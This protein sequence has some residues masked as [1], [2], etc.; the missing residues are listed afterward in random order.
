M[1]N[2][3]TAVSGL[4]LYV[5]LVVFLDHS[6]SNATSGADKIFSLEIWGLSA[7]TI[8]YAM[9]WFRRLAN[10]IHFSE[11]QFYI[12]ISLDICCGLGIRYDLHKFHLI[13]PQR[14]AAQP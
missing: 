11:M 1:A 13:L 8:A 7:A 9:M 4:V 6:Q 5:A 2:L 3:I 10:N 12:E 14:S